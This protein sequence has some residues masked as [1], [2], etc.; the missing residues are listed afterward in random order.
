MKSEF[1]PNIIILNVITRIC[2]PPMNH[3]VNRVF[4]ELDS[5]QLPRSRIPDMS[6]QANSLPLKSPISLL[7]STF[8]D[9][10]IV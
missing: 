8:S 1:R 10:T 6:K 3:S 9:I 7:F 5:E 4:N 2:G